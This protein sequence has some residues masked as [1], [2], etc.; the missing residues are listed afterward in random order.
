[1]PVQ[2][3]IDRYRVTT[4]AAPPDGLLLD[5][6]TLPDPFLIDHGCDNPQGHEA[7]ATCG[8][9]VCRHCAKV[10]WR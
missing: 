4:Y 1:M 8:E 3:T 5:A 6:S 10:F 9:I 7:I 2:E